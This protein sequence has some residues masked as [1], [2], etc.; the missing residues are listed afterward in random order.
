MKT[1]LQVTQPVLLLGVEALFLAL[2][3]AL[4]FGLSIVIETKEKLFWGKLSSSLTG[5]FQG[6]KLA[7]MD[8]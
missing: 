5:I 1:Y 3:G 2:G 7:T 8:L 6:E 4:R